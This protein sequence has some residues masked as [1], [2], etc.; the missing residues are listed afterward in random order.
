MENFICRCNVAM[1][2]P[3]TIVGLS[4]IHTGK[5]IALYD[6]AHAMTTRTNAGQFTLNDFAR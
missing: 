1:S 6:A 5:V 2:A 4:L 3:I